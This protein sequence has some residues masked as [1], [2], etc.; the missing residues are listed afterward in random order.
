MEEEQAADRQDQ[1]RCRPADDQAADAEPRRVEEE[2]ADA[3]AH[4]GGGS[5]QEDEQGDRVA[6][7]E[8]QVEGR[9]EEEGEEGS[10]VAAADASVQELRRRH[11]E[12]GGKWD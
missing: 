7:D 12:S 9:G 10:V 3:A 4:R 6:D 5:V 1:D 11:C 8:E 2:F